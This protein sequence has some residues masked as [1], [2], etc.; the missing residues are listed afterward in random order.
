MDGRLGTVAGGRLGTG[1]PVSHLQQQTRA[2][3]QKKCSDGQYTSTI[4][5]LIKEKKFDDV[6]HILQAQL[7]D[8]PSSRPALSLLAYSYYHTED[9]ASASKCYEKLTKLYPDNEEYKLYLAQ[10]LSKAQKYSEAVRAALTIE[11]SDLQIRSQLV[12]A[13]ARYGEDDRSACRTLLESCPQDNPDVL[14]NQACLLF[15]EEQYEEARKKYIEA[16]N[17][18]GYS[19][20]LSYC[21][22]LCSY[23][24]R[25]L[26][27]ALKSVKE[28][29]DRG[30]QEH[31]ELAVGSITDGL[32]VCSVGNSATLRE[33]ALI[34]AFNLKMAIQYIVKNFDAAH[35]ALTDMPPRSEAEIDPVSLHNLSLVNVEKDSEDSF[36]KFNFLL[37]SNPCPPETFGNL[38]LLYCKFGSYDAAADLLA[39]NLELAYVYLTTEVYEFL[40]A[41][42]QG[43]TSPEEAFAKFDALS[44]KHFST[45]R[46]LTKQVQDA[47]LA[48]DTTATR[49]AIRAYDEALDSFI[50]VLMAQAKVYWD[51]ENYP[52]V[53]KIFR[54][55][56]EFCSEH[57]T[58]KLNV[59]H[60]FFMH[61]TRYADAIRYYE[62]L[63]REQ[64]DNLLGVT[65]IVLANLCVAYIMTSQNEDAE[66]LMR[67]VEKEEEAIEAEDPTKQTVHLCIINL[68]I[69]TLYCS[70]GN[71]EF[72]ISRVIRSLEPYSRKLSTDTWY[73]AKRCLVAL[74]DQIAKQV[75]VLKDTVMNDIVEFLEAIEAHGKN[76]P[77]ST[78]PV[79]PTADP[80]T[81]TVSHEARLMKR[82]ILQIREW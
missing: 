48:N 82:V 3:L 2:S 43:Q 68:V 59:A 5:T 29:I 39:E 14:I 1:L 52:A 65:A 67:N 45:L 4:Y 81:L 41:T 40:E 31:P 10:S 77:C 37:N 78:G 22:A 27:P 33:S 32:D 62:P 53:E 50:P 73:Y 69:G 44:N 13:S 49:Q 16:L 55:S 6:I 25:Q 46:T 75:V 38:L 34:E 71:F 57:E 15:K 64:E 47:R 19:P 72:G 60:V 79:D 70:K 66:D 30:M 8:N 76:V 56:S 35:E 54:T 9:F 24:L 63:V 17:S 80:S 21:I 20:V 26:G 51:R 12:Q 7:Q 36:E 74:I 42:I 18:I 23:K 28:I 11:S 61:E 58:W